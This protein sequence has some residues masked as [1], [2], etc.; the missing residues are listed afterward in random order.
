VVHPYTLAQR[1]GHWYLW[2]H[3]EGRG[4]ALPFRLDRIRECA[5]SEERFEAPS[6]AQLDRARLFSD[7]QG[8]PIRIR[9]EPRAAA[10]ALSRPG[11]S[12]VERAADG[13]T[14]VEVPGAG[15]DWATRF[16]LSFGGDAEVIAPAA[17]RRHF[18][19]TVKRS[20]ARYA[21]AR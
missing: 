18:A 11:V 5:L 2:G 3:D 8:E 17:A 1:L 4:K 19:E 7:A 16:A 20:L 14:V 12:L 13:A 6:A 15:E 21:P 9:L 10:W